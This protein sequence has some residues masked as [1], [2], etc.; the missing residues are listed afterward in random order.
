MEEKTTRGGAQQSV[1]KSN[2]NNRLA[3]IPQQVAY[4]EHHVHRREVQSTRRHVRRQQHLQQQN[5]IGDFQLGSTE[6]TSTFNQHSIAISTG[7]LNIQ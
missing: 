6:G 5:P 3:Q 4:L 7:S 2:L 1:V